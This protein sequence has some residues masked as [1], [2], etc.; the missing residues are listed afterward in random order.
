MA[1][2]SRSTNQQIYDVAVIFTL[3]NT[4]R[5]VADEFVGA[6]DLTALDPAIIEVVMGVVA[7]RSH[8]AYRSGVNLVRAILDAAGLVDQYSIEDVHVEGVA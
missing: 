8:E 2:T 1:T 4:D 6:R 7:Q 3:C 5:E